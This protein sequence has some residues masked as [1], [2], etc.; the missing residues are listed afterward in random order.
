MNVKSRFFSFLC[1]YKFL[2]L[3]DKKQLPSSVDKEGAVAVFAAGFSAG[4][5]W[6]FFPPSC[7]K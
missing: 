6:P 7:Q 5:P 1:S 2:V 4:F 3:V